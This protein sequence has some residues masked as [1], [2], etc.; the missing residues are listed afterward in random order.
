MS[1]YGGF[2]TRLQ[3]TQ[4]SALVCSLLSLLNH[5][6]V[7][8]LKGDYFDG[9]HWLSAFTGVYKA[10][11][12]MEIQK[13]QPP[14][15]S[16]YCQDLILAYRPFL[17]KQDSTED[18][19][20]STAISGHPKEWEAYMQQ[21]VLE[22]VEGMI[23]EESKL[24]APKFPSVRHEEGLLKQSLRTIPRPKEPFSPSPVPRGRQL[25]IKTPTNKEDPDLLQP[26]TTAHSRLEE[27]SD[28]SSARKRR[29]PRRLKLAEIYQDRG[30]T[31][32]LAELRS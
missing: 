31:R 19:A 1:V 8:A 13:Y 4:Y 15:Y 9:D 12:R 29:K 2:A 32:L 14:K 22:K 23:L 28:S 7:A 24:P 6:I 27:L 3:E 11:R 10:M 18:S 5:R 20:V 17:N 16:H 25:S 30:Y 26:R 21:D